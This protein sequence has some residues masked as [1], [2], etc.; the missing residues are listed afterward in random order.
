M[1]E[2]VLKGDEPE[3]GLPRHRLRQAVGYAVELDEALS[4][5]HFGRLVPDANIVKK[6][7]NR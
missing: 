7:K 4:L 1:G 2:D 5:L 3:H 6:L